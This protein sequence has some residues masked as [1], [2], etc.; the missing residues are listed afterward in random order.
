MKD[1]EYIVEGY[2]YTIGRDWINVYRGGVKRFRIEKTPKVLAHLTKLQ[3][4]AYGKAKTAVV[5][6]FIME[7]GVP[8]GTL[9]KQGE[10]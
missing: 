1:C 4:S 9:S 3:D 7:H 10:E 5:C 2:H 6:D 8:Y